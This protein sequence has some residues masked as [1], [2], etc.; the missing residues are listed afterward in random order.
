[1]MPGTLTDTVDLVWDL[2]R[3]RPTL[4]GALVLRQEGEILARLGH[5][6]SIDLHL[7]CAEAGRVIAERLADTVFASSAFTFHLHRSSPPVEGWPAASVRAFPEFSY[8]SFSRLLTLCDA[9]GLTPRLAWHPRQ[10]G[11]AGQVRGRF[12]GHL[13]CVH[14][15]S[16]SPF[17]VEE[18]NADGPAWAKFFADHAGPGSLDFLLLGD[19]PLPAGFS[20]RPGVTRAAS[21]GMDLAAQ[22]ALVASADG[23]LGMASGVCTAAN[24]SETPHVIFKHPAHHP[25]DMARELGSADRFPFAGPRQRLWRRVV[26]PETLREALTLILS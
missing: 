6:S 18:S 24:L 1:M 3:E 25:A 16:V 5:A 14:L 9:N 21:L 23:F 4:G 7:A 26:S 11:L 8:F 10:L 15:R 12:P 17:A 22:L 2:T 20:Q 13:V 19:D